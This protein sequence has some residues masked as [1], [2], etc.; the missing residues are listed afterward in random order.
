VIADENRVVHGLWVGDRLSKLELLTLSS[1]V[2]HGHAFHLWLYSDVRTPLPRGVVVRDATAILPRSAVFTKRTTDPET[3]VGRGS[4]S[5]PFSDL[6]RYKLLLEHGGYW[7]DLDV[8]CLKP[9]DFSEPYVF[10]RH[11]VG[12]VGN[13]MKC[14]RNSLLMRDTYEE[15]V[16][17]ASEE[18]PWLTLNRILSR[19]VERLGL[20]SYIRPRLCNDDSWWTVVKPMLEGDVPIPEDYYV[21]H[22]INEFWRTLTENDGYYRGARLLDRVPDKNQVART[23]TLGRLYAAYGL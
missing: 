1:F 5:S 21:L 22:W 17:A 2:A 7:A 6:F 13:I 12:V 10:R 18:T 23:C 16:A 19:N 11:R 14:P 4:L 3:G 8:T 20:S 9:L 15:A